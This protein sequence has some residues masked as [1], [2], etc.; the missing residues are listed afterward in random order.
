VTRVFKTTMM[1][2]ALAA[3]PAAFALAQ[4]P[5]APAKAAAAPAAAGVETY[6]IDR[7]HSDATFQVRHFVSKVRGRFGDFEG[8]VQVDQ[9]RPEASAV[10]FKIKAASI[11]T[12]NA[13]RDEHLRSPDFFDVANHPEITFK[14]SKVVA[15]GQN[16]YDVTGTFSM[17]GVSKELTIPV[18]FLGFAKDKR[19]TEKAGFEANTVLNRKD[20]GIVWNRA[21]DAGG[22]LLG[23]EVYVS[24]NLETR[25][26]APP[27]PSAAP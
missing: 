26:E 22:V 2:A 20:F 15:R 3:V 11:D 27:A 7:N 1:A 17:H 14:S 10:E 5:A 8:T 18:T 19:G 21:L 4:A 16:Q 24:V 25:Q 12:A 9:A 23:D 6:M 13:Q